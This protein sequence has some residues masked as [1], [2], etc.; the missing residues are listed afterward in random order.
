MHFR[1]AQI[2]NSR[3][4]QDFCG[5]DATRIFSGKFWRNR[6]ASWDRDYGCWI[7]YGK[8]T[9]PYENRFHRTAFVLQKKTSEYHRAHHEEQKRETVAITI[10][11][12]QLDEFSVVSWNR[13]CVWADYRITVKAEYRPDRIDATNAISWHDFPRLL[14]TNTQSS[15]F[16]KYQFYRPEDKEE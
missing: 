5:I 12:K 9:K 15:S 8:V 14:P 16:H 7:F 13:R 6:L 2:S 3:R 1:S 11:L 10:N 4:C